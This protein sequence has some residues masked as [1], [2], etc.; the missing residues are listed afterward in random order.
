MWD[1]FGGSMTGLRQQFD[2][3]RFEDHDGFSEHRSEEKPFEI[4]CERCNR[5][6]YV[7]ASL[8]EDIASNLKNGFESG[9]ICNACRSL[10][11]ELA[12]PQ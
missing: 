2:A 4:G 8:G 10:D 9:V 1:L 5:S 7:S 3:D 12:F 11:D 6:L